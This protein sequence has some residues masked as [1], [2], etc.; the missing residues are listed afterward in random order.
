MVLVAVMKIGQFPEASIALPDA[1][2][3]NLGKDSATLYKMA[4]ICRNNGYGLAA[5]GYM[6]RVVEDKTNEL[7]EVVAKYAEINEVDAKKVEKIRDAAKSAGAYTPY[8]D[9]LK[10]ASAVFPESLKAAGKNPLLSL[11][12]L[13]SEG[14]HGKS[15]EECI[16]VAEDT[17]F[18]FRYVF[19]NLRAETEIK[20]AYPDKMKE[21]P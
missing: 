20:K 4:L 9:K 15:E 6:R 2:E 16:R 5:A 17:D 7:I 18:V 11:F 1:L 8:E 3:K 19:A 10:I 21:L 12:K 13:V 14:I